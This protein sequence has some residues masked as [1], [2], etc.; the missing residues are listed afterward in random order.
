MNNIILTTPAMLFPGISLLFLAYTQRFL[1]L[2]NL[3][4]N[5][6]QRETINSSEITK[7]NLQIVSLRK[8]LYLMRTMQLFG[9]VSF[10]LCGLSMLSMFLEWNFVGKI[11]FG[12]SIC[13]L[14]IS[15]LIS[16]FEI[17]LST[18]AI[19]IALSDMEI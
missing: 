16:F 5:L 3:I 12:V 1:A 19:N 6:Y 17:W 11:V 18:K 7:H 15:L 9:V 14:I 13:S 2:A 4:R 10:I 8:R